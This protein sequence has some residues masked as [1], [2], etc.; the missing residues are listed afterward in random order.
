MAKDLR[1]SI[2]VTKDDVGVLSAKVVPWQAHC[3]HDDGVEGGL[4][5]EAAHGCQ[6]HRSGIP[7]EGGTEGGAMGARKSRNVGPPK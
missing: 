5:V 4:A 7:L 6:L 3:F 2:G 1:G